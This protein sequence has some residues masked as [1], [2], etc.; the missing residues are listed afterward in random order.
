MDKTEL[1]S[2]IIVRAKLEMFGNN[3]DFSKGFIAGLKYVEDT[4]E[5]IDELEKTMEGENDNITNEGH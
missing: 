5:N 2:E 1:L 3:T 4:I